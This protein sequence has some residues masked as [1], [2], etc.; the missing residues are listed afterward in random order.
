MGE[1]STLG[2]VGGTAAVPKALA[3]TGSPG[4]KEETLLL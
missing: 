2:A 4:W 3:G 1:S